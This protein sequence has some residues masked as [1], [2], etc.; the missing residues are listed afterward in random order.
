MNKYGLSLLFGMKLAQMMRI[1]VD[2]HTFTPCTTVLLIHPL[3]PSKVTNALIYLI[4]GPFLFL[5]VHVCVCVSVPITPLT[6][7][8][9]K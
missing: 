9:P 7:S 1:L 5:S 6:H 4:T 8:A 2:S 3:Q